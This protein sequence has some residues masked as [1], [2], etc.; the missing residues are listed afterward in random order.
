MEANTN[1]LTTTNQNTW[2]LLGANLTH[3][4]HLVLGHSP[5]PPWRLS[6]GG[7]INSY[8]FIY[9]LFLLMS[10]AKSYPTPFNHSLFYIFPPCLLR[11]V[12]LLLLTTP[13]SI[14][15]PLVCLDSYPTSSSNCSLLYPFPCLL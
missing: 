4:Q 9:L 5:L 14:Y 11:I 7:D 10:V 1:Y 13:F 6:K 3:P 12:I 15:F 8:L 2:G